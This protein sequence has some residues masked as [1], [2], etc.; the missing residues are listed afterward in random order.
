MDKTWGSIFEMRKEFEL[1]VS[2][3]PIT[4]AEFEKTRNNAILALPGQWETNGA[5]AEAIAGIV[6]FGL[7][8]AYYQTYSTRLTALSLDEVQTICDQLI[9][10]SAM[11]WFV[12]GDREKVMPALAENQF[13]E[14]QQIDPNGE[15]IK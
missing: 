11:C 12:V 6:K 5:V 7:P 14:V 9:R 10:P 1:I 8:D 4:T 15:L 2:S 13:G 3:K